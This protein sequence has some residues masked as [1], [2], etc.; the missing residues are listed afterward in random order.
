MNKLVPRLALSTLY[1]CLETM[2][3]VVVGGVRQSGKTTL[4]RELIEDKRQFF[5]LD[6]PAILE[7]AHRRPQSLLQAGQPITIDEVQKCPKLLSVIKQIVDQHKQVG[8]FLLTGSANLLLMQSVNESLVGR[9]SY[10]NLRSLTRFEQLGLPVAGIWSQLLE[11]K[12]VDWLQIVNHNTHQPEDTLQTIVHKGGLPSSCLEKQTARQRNNWFADY[13]RAYL[14]RDLRDISGITQT[15]DLKRLMQ[16]MAGRLGQ[17]LNQ[18]GISRQ[19]GMAQATVHRYLNLLEVSYW[20]GKLPAYRAGR[21]QRLIKSPKI[22]WHDT[23]LAMYLSGTEELTGSHLENMVFNHLTV[24]SENRRRL[25]EPTDLYYWR[26][27]NGREVDFILETNDHLLP[28]EVKLTAYPQFADCRHLMAFQ[29]EF[30]SKVRA[31][32]LLHNGQLTD[33]L[34]PKVLAVPWWKIF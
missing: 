20:L 24:W 12:E 23:G 11:N 29:N 6:D 21:G 16:L 34:T 15:V 28:I 10:I 33:W 17:V 9:A 19:L 25:K 5:S 30:P 7:A 2:P 31:G 14:D 8:Q 1:D 13:C 26:T 3:V 4:V 27:T 22:Y 18:A 32:L